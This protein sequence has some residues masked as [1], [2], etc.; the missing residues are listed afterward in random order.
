MP[1]KMPR[2]SAQTRYDDDGKAVWGCGSWCEYVFVV[3]VA[4]VLLLAALIINVLW[5]IYYRGGYTLSMEKVDV[6]IFYNLHLTLLIAG[7]ITMSGFAILL[8]RIGRCCSHLVAKLIHLFLNICAIP[9]IGF[10]FFVGFWYRTQPAPGSDEGR[11]PFATLHSWLELITLGMFA[12]Q[13]VA[14]F[15]SFII[16]LCC[17]KATQKFRSVMVPIHASLGLATHLSAIGT[18]LTGL[19]EIKAKEV[20]SDAILPD[21]TI[22]INVIAVVLVAVGILIPFAIRR[23]N[24]PASFRV[25]VSENI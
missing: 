6:E 13:V 3:V 14:G 1:R 11:A 16:L 4:T 25:Y 21:E 18:I 24:S 7:Y 9:L 20:K 2:N 5:V 23:S 12:F 15:F 10:A 19:N 8:Y 17:E 22:V